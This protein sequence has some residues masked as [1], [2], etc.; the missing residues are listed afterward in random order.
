MRPAEVR[1]SSKDQNRGAEAA[2]T[3][4]VKAQVMR[5]LGVSVLLPGGGWGRAAQIS[6]ARGAAG[7]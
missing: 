5:G 2:P 4:Q 3:A 6:V 7:Y 1:C